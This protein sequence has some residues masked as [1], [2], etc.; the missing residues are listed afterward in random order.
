MQ[1]YL[2][3]NGPDG[4]LGPNTIKAIQKLVGT[5]ADGYWGPNTSKA[6]QKWL[7]ANKTLPKK[8]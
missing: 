1:K 3:M 5:T 6:F 8:K 4:Y 2:N 7:N